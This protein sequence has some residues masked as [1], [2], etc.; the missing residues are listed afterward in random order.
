VQDI[1]GPPRRDPFQLM[2]HDTVQILAAFA[3]Q[4][5]ER[6]HQN[7]VRRQD[8]VHVTVLQR[9]SQRLRRKIAA[10]AAAREAQRLLRRLTVMLLDRIAVGGLNEN[11][12]LAPPE[13]AGGSD[14][15]IDKTVDEPSDAA[16]Y[17]PEHVSSSPH[18]TS[19]P[20]QH[21]ATEWWQRDGSGQGN[22]RIRAGGLASQA[23]IR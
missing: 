8:K 19:N 11:D 4:R 20:C 9:R 17:A 6:A 15:G 13:N 14:P 2:M 7:L 5:I 23:R 10:I 22:R 3:R 21:L 16:S 18:T 12:P 1:V